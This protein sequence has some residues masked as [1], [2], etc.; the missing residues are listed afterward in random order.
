M[1]ARAAVCPHDDEIDLFIPGHLDDLG[2]RKARLDNRSGTHS[3][4]FGVLAACFH[5][6]I[7]LFPN[8]IHNVR[9]TGLG[10]SR[11]VHVD[12]VNQNQDCLQLE[13]QIDGIIQGAIR[14]FTE[15]KW[16]KDLLTLH[17]HPLRYSPA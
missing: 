13:T 9:E 5:V 16:Y 3:C 7:R 14:I 6:L 17:L 1:Q 15:I 8:V 2:R 10:S 11:Q 12:D 4:V